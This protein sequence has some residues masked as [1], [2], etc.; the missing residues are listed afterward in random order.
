[1]YAPDIK[2]LRCLTNT[3]HIFIAGDFEIVREMKENI[4]YV[5]EDYSKE[6]T[7]SECF[8]DIDKSYELPDGN[9]ITIGKER[10]QCPEMLF[11]PS[12]GKVDL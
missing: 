8:P 12:K 1:M 10:F 11:R 3:T 6:I 9:L 4:C 5:A 2:V 7:K